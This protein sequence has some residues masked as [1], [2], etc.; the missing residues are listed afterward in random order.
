MER[1]SVLA[2]VRRAVSG[3]WFYS[4]PEVSLDQI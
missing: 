2:Q 1:G 4:S 3:A